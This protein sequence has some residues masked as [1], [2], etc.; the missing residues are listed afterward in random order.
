MAKLSA[1]QESQITVKTLLNLFPPN[2]SAGEKI[3]LLIANKFHRAPLENGFDARQFID[4]IVQIAHSSPSTALSFGMH[5]HTVWGMSKLKDPAARRVVEDIAERDNLIASLNDP[6]IYLA[7]PSMFDRNKFPLK[8]KKL[9]GGYEISGVKRFVSLEPYVKK[10]P[11]FAALTDDQTQGYGIICAVTDKDSSGISTVN[12][13]N[14]LAMKD[15]ASNSLKFD[16]VFIPDDSVISSEAE[17]T[18]V[19]LSL[20]AYLFRLAV[21]SVYFGVAQAAANCAKEEARKRIIPHWE[22]PLTMFPSTQYAYGEIL[23]WLEVMRSQIESFA[24]RVDNC[25][26][27]PD[28][29]G[30][31]LN[32]TSLITKKFITETAERVV[33]KCTA[34]VGIATLDKGHP[35]ASLQLDVQAGKFHPPQADIALE[36]IAR[37]ALGIIMYRNR[38]L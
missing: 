28:R 1:Y 3:D 31:Q 21:S 34:I 24:G 38:W 26:D 8:A 29:W 10:V 17:N 35:L 30:E 12:D 14:S 23:Q 20:Q 15:T 22:K 2:C 33:E 32:Q 4:L 27:S 25:I 6:G 16:K 13:W 7:H 36:S 37:N 5:L 18:I 19:K 9:P 11:F